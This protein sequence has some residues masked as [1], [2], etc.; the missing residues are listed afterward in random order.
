M[1]LTKLIYVTFKVMGIHGITLKTE[2]LIIKN[3]KFLNK[4]RAINTLVVVCVNKQ[5]Y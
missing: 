1:I 4:G 2:L 5:F 3:I